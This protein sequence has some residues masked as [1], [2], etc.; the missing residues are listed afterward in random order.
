[1]VSKGLTGEVWAVI[2]GAM[3]CI[4]PEISSHTQPSD[5]AQAGYPARRGLSALSPASLEYWI[6]RPRCAIAHKADDDGEHTFTF[7]RRVSP[8]LC[9]PFAQTRGRRECRVLAAPAVPCARDGGRGAHEHTGTVGARRH[10]LRSGF[11]AYGALSPE[12]NSSCLRH[13]RIDGFAN[14]VGLAKTS[15][16]LTPATGARTTR[17][18]RTLQHRSS[19]APPIAHRPKPALQSVSAQRVLPRPP[20]SLPNVRDDRDTPLLTGPGTGEVVGLIWGRG[21][22]VYFRGEDWTG[23]IRL[24]ALGKLDRTKTAL[25]DPSAGF[26]RSPAV[27]RMGRAK[28]NPSPLSNGYRFAPPIPRT[29]HPSRCWDDV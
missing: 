3:R 29:H 13:R 27:R 6:V 2:P 9:Q 1:M 20:H 14:P 21:E 11:T 17:F 10:S 12:T 22:E 26:C 16:D 5:P 8:G 19:A 23:Q 15:A 25:R 24:I 28:R 18:C 7:P 4:E